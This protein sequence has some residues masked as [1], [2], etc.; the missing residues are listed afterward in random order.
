MDKLAKFYCLIIDYFASL[1]HL[2]NI[3][4]S[5]G[6]FIT[7]SILVPW[8][9]Q[10]L[11]TNR[12]VNKVMTNKF[13][14]R[15]L[16]NGLLKPLAKWT[17]FILFSLIIGP[18]VLAGGGLLSTYTWNKMS[19]ESQLELQKTAL[20]TAVVLEWS[21]NH[22]LLNK[23]PIEGH[24]YYGE[25]V[26]INLFPKLITG[27]SDALL[28]SG[29]FDFSRPE[30]SKVFFTI[31]NYNR[32]IHG[33]NKLFLIFNEELVKKSGEGRIKEAEKHQKATKIS[34]WGKN[35]FTQNQEL[36]KLLITK[37]FDIYSEQLIKKPQKIQ[38]KKEIP[39]N[40]STVEPTN[41]NQ[42][43]EQT[44]GTDSQEG[45]QQE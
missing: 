43:Q 33:A 6:F 16:P 45:E 32:A 34:P 30:D 12:P 13:M 10:L 5:V 39:Q 44:E 9:W 20:M 14:R 22:N 35:L 7:G 37:Y 19:L 26:Y 3:L 17:C 4:W 24:V 11:R 40:A 21:L 31:L 41:V 36:H 29:L 18:L 8:G 27:S 23:S 42:P 25:R 28:A 15:L 2:Y 38:Q 1:N